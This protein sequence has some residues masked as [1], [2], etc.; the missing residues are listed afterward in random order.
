M[1]FGTIKV[2]VLKIRYFLSLLRL[3]VLG[4][5]LCFDYCLGCKCPLSC[6]NCCCVVFAEDAESVY[7]D[8]ISALRS[9]KE[10]L[11]M[12]LKEREEELKDLSRQEA[13][14]IFSVC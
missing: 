5:I 11:E 4:C 6:T 13:V 2:I 9:K 14:S 3:W 10:M 7:M 8:F 12:R 1:A